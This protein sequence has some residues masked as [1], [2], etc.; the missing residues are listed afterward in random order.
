VLGCPGITLA[1]V[2]LKLVMLGRLPA[3]TVTAAVMD[4]KALVAV[5]V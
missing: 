4:P 3:A 2:A 5:S 1:G